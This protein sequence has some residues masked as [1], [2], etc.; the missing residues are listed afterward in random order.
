MKLWPRVWC[1]VFFD[2]RCTSFFDNNRYDA[3]V[4]KVLQ[5]VYMTLYKNAVLY[6]IHIINEDRVRDRNPGIP[7]LFYVFFTFLP[8]CSVGAK[9][10]ATNRIP[11]PVDRGT[12]T[13]YGG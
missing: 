2:S 5:N 13:R 4:N 9:L 1:L 10:Q 12:A 11:R 8:S 3:I 7:N 6:T